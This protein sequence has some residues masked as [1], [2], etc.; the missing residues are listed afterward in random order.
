MVTT[1]DASAFLR[2]SA[3]CQAC[4]A[5]AQQVTDVYEKSGQ[6]TFAGSDVLSMR[7]DAPS[8]PTYVVEVR[9]SRLKIEVPGEG[10]HIPSRRDTDVSDDT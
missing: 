8:P 3:G 7:E 9:A 5:Y 2:M 6:V 10:H 4:T 1:G